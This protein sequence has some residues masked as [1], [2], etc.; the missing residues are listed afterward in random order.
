MHAG[1]TSPVP[2][3]D[4]HDEQSEGSDD[5]GDTVLFR[6][7]RGTFMLHDQRALD[8]VLQLVSQL[9]AMRRQAGEVGVGMLLLCDGVLR[10]AL[11]L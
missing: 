3:V 9:H 7:V 8:E 10:I 5:N 4:A 6:L 2:S 1:R 11:R